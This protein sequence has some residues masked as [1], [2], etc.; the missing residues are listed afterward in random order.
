[1]VHLDS[2]DTD[3]VQSLAYYGH[4][5]SICFKLDMANECLNSRL[6]ILTNGIFKQQPSSW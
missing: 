4:N 3:T 1:M 5:N 2:R 6:D